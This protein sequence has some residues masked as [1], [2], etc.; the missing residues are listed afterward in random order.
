M[1]KTTKLANDKR[2]QSNISDYNAK[3]PAKERKDL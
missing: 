1:D 2:D 3:S